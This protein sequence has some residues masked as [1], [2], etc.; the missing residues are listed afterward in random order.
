MLETYLNVGWWY[1]PRLFQ[2]LRTGCQEFLDTQPGL[3]AWK[4]RIKQIQS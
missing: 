1:L 2:E 3:P 4:Q